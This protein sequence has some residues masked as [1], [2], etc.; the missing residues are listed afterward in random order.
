MMN[1]LFDVAMTLATEIDNFMYSYDT[2][3]Y[4]DDVSDPQANIMAICRDI[5]CGKVSDMKAYLKDIADDD[6]DEEAGTAGQLL[7]RL[8]AFA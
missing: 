3:G 1:N 6:E 2:Y 5:I 4:Q 7:N 8:C